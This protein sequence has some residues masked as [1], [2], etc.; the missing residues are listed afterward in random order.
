MKRILFFMGVFAFLTT[1]QAGKTQE[2]LTRWIKGS[3]LNPL[4]IMD[5]IDWEVGEWQEFVVH[6]SFGEGEMRK[7]VE[8]EEDGAIWVVTDLSILG[9]VQNTRALVRRSDARILRFIVNGNEQTPPSEEQEIEILEQ[10]TE[11]IT[12]PAG[13]YETLYVKIRAMQQGR[14]IIQ[15]IWLAPNEVVME[16]SVKI[17]IPD[18]LF[19][20]EMELVR[21]GS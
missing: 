19:N 18:N 11:T 16:G 2:E 21:Y 13:M 14:E 8:S 15:E 1:A 7:V 3:T 20:V 10:R 5:L 4:A 9:Q 17:R 12:V 6:T